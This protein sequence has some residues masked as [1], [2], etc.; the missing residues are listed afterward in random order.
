[1]SI[2]QLRLG[3]RFR[4]AVPLSASSEE[5]LC[6]VMRQSRDVESQLLIFRRLKL[7]LTRADCPRLLLRQPQGSIRLTR[8]S[9]ERS[10]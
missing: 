8:S 9:Q 6:N 2:R 3:A 7:T 4:H 10:A 1:M 5:Q